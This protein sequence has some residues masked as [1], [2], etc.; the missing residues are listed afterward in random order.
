MKNILFA[1]RVPDR[2]IAPPGQVTWTVPGTYEW[3]VPEGVYSVCALAIGPGSRGWING[4]NAFGGRGG[5]LRWR[6]N[7]AVVPGQKVQV[8]VATNSYPDTFTSNGNIERLEV[9][10]QSSILGLAAGEYASGTPVG[11]EVGGGNGGV[12]DTSGYNKLNGGGPSGTPIYNPNPNGGTH[13]NQGFNPI[14]ML[15][16]PRTGNSNIGQFAGGGG[17]AIPASRNG[18]LNQVWRG[19]QGAVRVIWGEGRAYPSTKVTDQPTVA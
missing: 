4:A 6:N 19:G 16:V 18:G 9:T 12:Y 7:I 15:P 5:G 1:A 14:T 13:P 3:V 10:A 8:I 17:S 2:P 11:G